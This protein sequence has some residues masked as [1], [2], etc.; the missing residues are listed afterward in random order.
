MGS[1]REIKLLE[2]LSQEPLISL[3]SLS[4]FHVWFSNQRLIVS[5]M[6]A[7]GTG[8]RELLQKSKF[9]QFYFFPHEHSLLLLQTMEKVQN[10]DSEFKSKTP[11]SLDSIPEDVTMVIIKFVESWGESGGNKEEREARRK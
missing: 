5:S 2:M 11:I 7:L 8:S 1:G 6:I 3:Y 4:K 9:S 10:V